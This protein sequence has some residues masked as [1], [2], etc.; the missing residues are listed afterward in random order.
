MTTVYGPDE[1]RAHELD[2]PV[3]A[4]DVL[5][6]FDEAPVGAPLSDDDRVAIERAQG[7]GRHCVCQGVRCCL[8]GTTNPN[9]ESC[10][11]AKP[12]ANPEPNC[13][14]CGGAGF[15]VTGPADSPEQVQCEDC[16]QERVFGTSTQEIRIALEKGGSACWPWS[17]DSKFGPEVVRIRDA[18]GFLVV[19][20]LDEAQAR[21]IIDALSHFAT[22]ST[23]EDRTEEEP[24]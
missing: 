10:P 15:T 14:T 12:G 5:R 24:F 1:L 3:S 22:G 7:E 16:F 17:I 9:G 6:A 23:D 13:P 21:L 8:C 20:Q 18:D 2:P 11:A 4:D 19:E